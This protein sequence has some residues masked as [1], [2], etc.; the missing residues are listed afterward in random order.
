MYSYIYLMRSVW[1]SNKFMDLMITFLDTVIASQIF[2]HPRIW[3]PHTTYYTNPE[4]FYL[5]YY[6]KIEWRFPNFYFLKE[7]E[8]TLWEC[9]II[10]CFSDRMMKNIAQHD[11]K[12]A[13]EEDNFLLYTVRQPFW[14]FLTCL[15]KSLIV[16]DRDMLST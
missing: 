9:F 15:Q 16:Q 11:Q 1:D 8:I 4:K 5:I 12:K 6:C 10:I 3:N 14:Q 2:P 13:E 7:S